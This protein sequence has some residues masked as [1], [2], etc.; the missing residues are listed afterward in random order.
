MTLDEIHNQTGKHCL[1]GMGSESSLGSVFH[2]SRNVMKTVLR[3][4]TNYKREKT[5]LNESIIFMNEFLS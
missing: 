1:K 5:I 2:S 3:A 4:A